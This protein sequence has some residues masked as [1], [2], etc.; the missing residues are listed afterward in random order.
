[1]SRR[2]AVVFTP[3]LVV[4]SLAVGGLTVAS[5]QPSATA[6]NGI[7]SCTTIDSSGRYVLTSDITNS[8]ASRCIEVQAD[9]VT[10]DGNGHVVS[11]AVEGPDG[12][13]VSAVY[14]DGVSNLTVTDVTLRDWT[15][16]VYYRNGAGGA[17]RNVTAVRNSIGVAVVETDGVLVAANTLRHNRNPD[18]DVDGAGVVVTDST[19]VTVRNNVA[20]DNYDDV[21]TYGASD[22]VVVVGN[23]LS[24][25]AANADTGSGV[26][27]RDAV[28]DARVAENAA[29]GTGF[30]LRGS[31]LTVTSNEVTDG[32]VRLHVGESTVDE[33]AVVDGT[34][35]VE[36]TGGETTVSGNAVTNG[37]LGVEATYGTTSTRTVVRDNVVTGGETGL[38]VSTARTRLANNTVTDADVG[39]YL[40]GTADNRTVVDNE[41]TNT[42]TA[43][44]VVHY[45]GSTIADNVFTGNTNGVYVE[46]VD[47]TSDCPNLTTV[48]AIHGNDLGNNA[49]YGIL[50]EGDGV[51]NATGNDWGAADGPSSPTGD[52]LEDPVSG[53]LANGSGTMV[54]E[55]PTDGVTNVH[56][57]TNSTAGA[58]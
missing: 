1:M 27:F 6:E 12:P 56:F 24:E 5:V 20:V 49:E 46:S 48:G 15:S 25:T 30:D 3:V 2:I 52:P 28:A 8:S 10:I 17:V 7:D 32:R 35:E 4:G 29:T 42:T 53:A 21:R 19:N 37:T 44:R 55:G 57:A 39:I 43:L 40:L 23:R 54:S 13:G 50:N 45:D 16:G 9:D 14:A 11:G 18:E 51:L 31:N 34:L 38:R 58:G 47:N 41:V 33:N 22:G 36:I 26:V